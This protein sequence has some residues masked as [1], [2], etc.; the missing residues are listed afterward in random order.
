[1]AG[2]ATYAASAASLTQEVEPT[3]TTTTTVASSLNPSTYGQQVSFT[4]TVSPTDG[5][6]TVSFSADQS[7]I[8]GCTAEQ[9]ALTSGSYEATCTTSSL[10]AGSHVVSAAYSGDTS[11]G[12]SSSSV[13]QNVRTPTAT[14]VS[15]SPSPVSYGAPVTFTATVSPTDGSGTV[16]FTVDGNPVSGCTGQSVSPVSGNYQATCTP[17]SLAVGSHEFAAAFSGDASY[18]PS[19]ASGRVTIAKATPADAVTDSGPVALGNSVTFTATISGPAGATAPTGSIT[20][21]VSGSAGATS[22]TSSTT[23]LSSGTA[24][25]TI[26][27]TQAGTYAISDNYQGDGNYN[28]AS[29]SADTVTVTPLSTTTAL[30]SSASPSLYSQAVTFTAT[31]SPTDGGGTVGFTADGK[32]VTGCSGQPLTLASGSYQATCTTSALASGSHTIQASYSGDANFS[33]SSA[34]IT[35]TVN[36]KP[37][38][39]A[40]ASSLNP[41]TYG[42]LVTFTATVSPT[43][44]HGGITFTSGTGK[45]A[46]TLC[47]AQSLTLVK[48]SYQATCT[49]STLAASTTTMI[50]ASYSGDTDYSKSADTVSQTI[51]KTPTTTVLSS[52][53]NPVKHGQSITLTA[54]VRSTDGAGTVTFWNVGNTITDCTSEPLKETAGTY[55][56]TCTTP[57]LPGGTDHPKAV[58]TGDKNCFGSTGTLAQ[59]VKPEPTNTKLTS[60]PNPSTIGHTVTLTATITS[61]D[62][63]GTVSFTSNGHAISRCTKKT[64]TPDAKTWHAI[65]KTSALPVGTDTVKA[66][67]NGDVGHSI[68]SGSVKQVV[69]PKLCWMIR[70]SPRRRARAI[71][72]RSGW[73]RHHWLSCP[74]GH[75]YLAGRM[76]TRR[77]PD[78]QTQSRSVTGVTDARLATATH[79]LMA[80]CTRT[81]SD[82][83]VLMRAGRPLSANLR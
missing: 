67:Y 19:S 68:S 34:S 45:A 37:T 46:T 6:G 79:A 42:K 36:Q 57:A 30:S 22:C 27:V 13:T 25:C 43:D 77:P 74:F 20:W 28:P 26:H 80:V 83:F 70:A 21:L 55:A 63:S 39:T 24:T 9:L 78:R 51:N 72:G 59:V 10:T 15:A 81:A 71:T 54:M 8:T 53:K 76:W 7:P 48:G 18:A 69:I 50:T 1:M 64:L 4:A 32:A 60:T 56:A 52:S 40:V 12:S 17:P 14:T 58:Y 35:Q 82:V 38:T 61:T 31:V 65:C 2:I 29:S 66:T 11:Y 3:T 47:P 5:G 33:G 73:H 75:P 16:S 23:T 49:T 44:G 62:G 41:S